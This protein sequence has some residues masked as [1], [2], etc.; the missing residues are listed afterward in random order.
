MNRFLFILFLCVQLAGCSQSFNKEQLAGK[1]VANHP[2]GNDYLI[3]TVDGTYFYSYTD[4][5][6]NKT[7]N[8]NKWFLEH[9]N[10]KTIITFSEFN[11]ALPD[12]G[13]DSPGYWVVEVKESLLGE[14]R[15]TIDPDLDYY[16]SKE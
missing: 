16:Y 12:Y 13:T 7:I 6:D 14:I 11:F 3:L 15:L 9:K 1:Y 5:N 10:E 8:E 2:Y 4:V